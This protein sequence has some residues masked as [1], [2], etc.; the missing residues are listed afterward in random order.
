[1]F[2]ILQSGAGFHWVSSVVVWARCGPSLVCFPIFLS[3]ILTSDLV[4]LLCV[5]W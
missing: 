5:S 4:V 1:L 2:N 3:R